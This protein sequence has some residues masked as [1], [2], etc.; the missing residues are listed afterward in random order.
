[1]RKVMHIDG[2]RLERPGLAGVLEV[3]HELAG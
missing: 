1:V 3:A 2:D